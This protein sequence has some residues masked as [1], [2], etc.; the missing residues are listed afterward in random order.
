VSFQ[1]Y[2]FSLFL[3][4]ALAHGDS[5]SQTDWSGGSSVYGPDISWNDEFFDSDSI[6][7][8]ESP[9][10]ITLLLSIEEHY[11]GYLPSACCIRPKDI[12]QDGDMDVLV[13][14]DFD[15]RI[16]WFENND[17]DAS[18]AVQTID[19]N[20]EDARGAC[21][22]DIDGDG[23]FDVIGASAEENTIA[24]WS[25]LDGTGHSWTKYII[26]SSF[27]GA[28]SVCS[29][30]MDGDGDMD[31]VG[32]ASD[33][34]G[35]IAGWENLDGY[36][37]TW[38]KHSITGS[39][40]GANSVHLADLDND[41]DLDVIGA[42]IDADVVA[43]WLNEGPAALWTEVI[44]DGYFLMA[45][46][47]YAADIDGDGD[48]DVLGAGIGLGEIT[49]WENVDGSGLVWTENLITEDFD[50]ARSV[51][52]E[53][54]DADGDMDIIGGSSTGQMV[55]LWENRD[56]AGSSWIEHVIDAGVHGASVCSE[57]INGDGNMD[58]LAADP[59]TDKVFWWDVIGYPSEGSLESSCLYLQN[60]PGWDSIDWVSDELTGTSV[61]VQ[62]RSCDSPHPDSMGAWS[63]PL[64]APCSLSG[65]LDE[66]DSFFQYRVLLETSIP[67]A[68]P[69]LEEITVNWL[70]VA[71]SDYLEPIPAGTSLLPF[72][73]NP[74]TDVSVRFY[75][76]EAAPVNITVFDLS[77]RTVDENL[78]EECCSGFHDIQLLN[79]S[80][81]IYLCRM[82]SGSF[83]ATR[84]FVIVR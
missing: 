58:I 70:S 1:N 24:W 33:A 43:C 71:V 72:T 16:A 3:F 6:T 21:S 7:W 69:L 75:L 63:D 78:M 30:D 40:D 48:A 27:A 11:I 77:G 29:Q 67:K 45:S 68:T 84:K 38:A 66:N 17:T 13:A 83:V 62:V 46:C 15:G 52:A 26:D 55:H 8:S 51:W 35:E 80:P 41:G 73:P 49:W 59:W 74:S 34:G 19:I 32:A 60:D 20:F 42:A 23:D 39:F 36:G 54:I 37:T 61:S 25:N 31:V 22:E 12:D 79:F 81:G 44:I 18:W 64:T 53:D 56:G 10:E 50:G 76:T 65:I 28:S 4:A 82:T 5:V 2:L 9:G 14:G 47:V 57:D